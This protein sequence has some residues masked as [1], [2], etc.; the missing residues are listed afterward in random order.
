VFPDGRTAKCYL[1]GPAAE[2]AETPSSSEG[3]EPAAVQR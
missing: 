2:P 1:H 3:A